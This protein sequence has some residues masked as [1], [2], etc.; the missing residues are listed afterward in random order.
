MEN[1]LTLGEIF[2]V[3]LKRVWWVLGATVLCMVVMVLV[4]ELWYNKN[5]QYYSIGYELVYPGSSNG[6]YPDGSDLFAEECISIGNLNDIKN[7][8]YS[9]DN[10]AEFAGVNVE[11]MHENDELTITE[12]VVKTEDGNIKRQY[13]LTANA[14]YFSDA[15]QARAFLR[16]VAEYPVSRVNYIL[17]NRDYG[18][19]LPVYDSADEYSDAIN[20]LLS[21]KY[22]L[23]EEYRKLGEYGFAEE[24]ETGIAALHNILTETQQ[25]DLNAQI[26]ANRYV[27]NVGRFK[28]TADEETA[29]LRKKISDNEK[30]IALLREAKRGETAALAE[31]Y[32]PAV[33][34]K[35][36]TVNAI[37]AKV[38]GAISD[39]DPYDTEIARL[40]V[41]N[42]E[43]QNR[44]DDITETLA[45]IEKE[46]YAELKQEFDVRMDA[47][48]TSL[49]EAANTLKAVSLK[50]YSDNSRAVYASNKLEIQGGVFWAVSL[51]SGALAGL[52][53]SVAVVCIIDLPKYKRKKLT[54]VTE[55]SGKTVKGKNFN[56][57]EQ[58]QEAAA[59]KSE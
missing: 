37:G 14:K 38:A 23:E 49:Q 2:K 46:D 29:S 54:A 57:S 30:I 48:R 21:Q 22:Y 8:K 4:M 40:I 47:F 35:T 11:A 3:I 15:A 43:M 26:M 9:S 13:T 51:I 31:Q 44:I 55:Q 45:A 34:N 59:D 24:S 16:A 58:M 10:P 25:K 42:G 28:E 18:K 27:L 20:A 6:K 32:D 17:A 5:A 12:K 53:L 1:G 50:I 39:T 41:E 52:I 56:A 36:L 7:G 33:Y 19:R